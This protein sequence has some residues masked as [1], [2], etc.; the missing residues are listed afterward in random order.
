[1]AMTGLPVGNANSYKKV[2]H[3]STEILVSQ[4]KSRTAE[5]VFNHGWERITS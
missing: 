4:K 1:M 2:L 3:F 5:P